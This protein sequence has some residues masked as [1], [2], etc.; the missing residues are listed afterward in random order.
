[1]NH[2]RFNAGEMTLMIACAK[3]APPLK[4]LADLKGKTLRIGNPEQGDLAK[5]LGAV[6]VTLPTPDVS[7]ALQRGSVQYVITAAAAGGTCRPPAGHRG[8]SA[9]S[10]E[11]ETIQHSISLHPRADNATPC[12]RPARS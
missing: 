8:G 10:L 5:A 6:P 2:I 1:M 9:S 7:P 12:R 3:G 11:R 4:A